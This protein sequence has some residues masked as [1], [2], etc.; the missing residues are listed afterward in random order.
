MGIKT[1]IKKMIFPTSYSNEAYIQYLR[2]HGVVIGKNV[3]IY[4]PVHTDIDIRRPWLISIG[5]YC[6]ITKGVT[7]LAH[8]Y[9]VSVPRRKFGKFVG[10]SAGLYRKQCV[11]WN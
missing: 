11:Y 5:D 6:K 3:T 10:G 1:L 2:N 4:S 7:I 8:D 9:S